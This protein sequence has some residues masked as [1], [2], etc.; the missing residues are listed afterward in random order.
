MSS[1]SKRG[2]VC[3]IITPYPFF[4][5]IATIIGYLKDKHHNDTYNLSRL[6]SL[7]EAQ[8]FSV[9]MKE[10]FMMSPIG[11][12]YERAIENVMKLI[13]LR[14]LLLNQLIVGKIN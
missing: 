8:G 3:I 12:P 6:E 1:R 2:G 13:G 10:K 9:E 5:H 4:K 14:F 11:F 7:F